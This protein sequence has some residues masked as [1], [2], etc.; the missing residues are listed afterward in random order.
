MLSV[1]NPVTTDLV[2]LG[3]GH[4]HLFVLRHLAMNPQPGLR[5]T[6]ITR[7]INTPYSGMLPGYIAGHYDFDETHID[8]RPLARFANANLI[9]AEIDSIDADAGRI[10]FVD[11]PSM[12]YDLLSVN[13]GSRPT[14]PAAEG[15]TAWQV[16]VKPIDQFLQQ[17]QLAEQ[18]LLDRAEDLRV[19]VVGGGAGGVELALS[20]QH[21]VQALSHCKGRLVLSL[22]TGA[23][24][25]LPSHNRKVQAIFTQLFKDRGIP[26]I[27]NQQ[28]RGFDGK[29]LQTESGINIEADLVIWVTQASAAN[30][31]TTSGLALDDQGFVQVNAALQSTSHENVFAAGDIASV[32]DFTRPKS[33]V[34][35]VRHQ[36]RWRCNAGRVVLDLEGLD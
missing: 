12:S 9:H 10:D 24:V 5:I 22:V 19:V 33:G 34:F 8:L 30:W 11:R 32:V 26:V 2:L 18:R 15:N 36:S 4:S 31:L 6:L 3:G 25:L 13:I 7:D 29:R 20:L 16:G 23:R 17:W 27:H 35:A 21:R 14:I 28:V 1:I